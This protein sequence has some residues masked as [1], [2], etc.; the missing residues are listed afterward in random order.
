MRKITLIICELV[1]LLFTSLAAQENENAP[2][3]VSSV[4]ASNCR[5]HWTRIADYPVCLSELSAIV[6]QGRIFVMGG[7]QTGGNQD[8]NDNRDVNFNY[9]YDPGSNQWTPLAAM[10][11]ARY[12]VG[13][14]EIGGRI[15]AI[16]SKNES[17]DPV[18]DTWKQHA[19]LPHGGAHLGV[20]QTGGEIFAFGVEGADWCG[21][22]MAFNPITNAWHAKASI[23]TPRMFCAAVTFQ[24]KIYVM[25][26]LGYDAKGR[27]G[28]IRHE[29]EVYDPAADRWEAKHPM[30]D[31]IFGATGTGVFDGKIFLVGVSKGESLSASRI[32]QEIY[33]YNPVSDS[34]SRVSD[35]LPHTHHGGA[36]VAFLDNRI[37]LIGGNGENFTQFKDCYA[38]MI[39]C[40]SKG[41]AD[42]DKNH[43][44]NE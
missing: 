26:G 36:G 13:L 32:T 18:T 41:I 40:S 33:V 9:A 39:E 19:P 29:V 24:E 10:P 12:D 20:A 15:Y 22:N 31:G 43:G 5:I 1:V 2:A 11:T 7:K 35:P 8:L 17:Y 14:A 27:I 6:F 34:W 3:A 42:S 23:P 4:P 44:R 25:G 28:P 21:Q 37:T 30:P 16:S 38:G